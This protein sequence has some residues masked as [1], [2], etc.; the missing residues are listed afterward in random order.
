MDNPLERFLREGERRVIVHCQNLL[1]DP[2]LRI[3]DQRRLERLL[4]A[5][6]SGCRSS[7]Q[8]KINRCRNSKKFCTTLL[9]FA[10]VFVFG[11]LPLEAVLGARF[12]PS[13]F[14]RAP[15][16]CLALV[17]CAPSYPACS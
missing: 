10:F 16:N 3:E 13:G 4:A 12:G 15:D 11:F 5:A 9:N 14:N 1:R 17:S 2:N 8:L 6:E 7:P